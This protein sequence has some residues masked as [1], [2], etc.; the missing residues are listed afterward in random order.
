MTLNIDAHQHFWRYRPEAY[1]WIGPEM[2]AL[3]KDYLPEDLLPL[4]QAAG[5]D[6][7]VA[8]QAHASGR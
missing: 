1:A 5:M 3:K 8:V 6:G 7:A 4:L 2:Q